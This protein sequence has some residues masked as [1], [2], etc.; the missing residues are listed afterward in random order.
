V[1]TVSGKFQHWWVMGARGG[2]DEE[3]GIGMHQ[4]KLWAIHFFKLAKMKG[5][6]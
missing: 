1:L 6:L 3:K 4:A 2:Q 5:N